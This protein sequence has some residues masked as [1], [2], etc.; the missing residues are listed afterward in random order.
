M[1]RWVVMMS[2]DVSLLCCGPR[3]IKD[4]KHRCCL[5]LKVVPDSRSPWL[6][7]FEKSC[8]VLIWLLEKS[9][10]RRLRQAEDR[11]RCSLRHILESF[12]WEVPSPSGWRRDS[13]LVIKLLCYD[14]L[15]DSAPHFLWRTLPW[16]K[17]AAVDKICGAASLKPLNV[18]FLHL[19]SRKGKRVWQSM[20]WA[21]LE[22]G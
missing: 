12:F 20:R 14:F 18:A 9:W 21:W 3:T 8:G 6:K 15:E 16:R 17:S 10:R 1:T 11:Q 5:K 7:Y 13:D 4:P 2:I 19:L 22:W